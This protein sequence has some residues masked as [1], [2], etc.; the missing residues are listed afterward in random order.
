MVAVVRV[1]V[2]DEGAGEMEV[3]VKKVVRVVMRV[4]VMDEGAGEME[5]GMTVK[6]KVVGVARVS[7]EGKEQWVMMGEKEADKK[8]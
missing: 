6:E 3:I 1:M 8:N 7:G 4:M 2:K 5:E